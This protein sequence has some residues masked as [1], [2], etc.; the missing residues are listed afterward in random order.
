M[1]YTVRD[2]KLIPI[3]DILLLTPHFISCFTIAQAMSP[4]VTD[5]PYQRRQFVDFDANGNEHHDMLEDNQV[6][7]RGQ[8]AYNRTFTLSAYYVRKIGNLG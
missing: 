1:K 8:V 2:V 3:L 7:T 4:S 6:T 5:K